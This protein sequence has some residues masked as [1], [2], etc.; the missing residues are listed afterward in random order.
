MSDNGHGPIA[1]M[2][3]GELSDCEGCTEAGHMIAGL[4]STIRSQAAVISKLRVD[5][6]RDARNHP[7]WNQVREVHEYWQRHCGHPRSKFNAERFWLMLPFY[8]EDG[9]EVMRRSID[10]AAF[11]PFTTPR[12][13]GTTKRFDDVELI[14]RNRGKFEEFA[15]RAPR[16]VQA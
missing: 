1:N 15:N 12:K 5:R 10:G 16:N 14:F 13:N 9:P 8:E 7:R 3:T 6:E 4:E 2:K 11:D